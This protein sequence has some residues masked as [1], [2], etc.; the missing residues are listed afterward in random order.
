MEWLKR[1]LGFSSG[2]A[3]KVR[4]DDEQREEK[5]PE[6]EFIQVNLPQTSSES[7]NQNSNEI[8]DSAN[9]DPIGLASIPQLDSSTNQQGNR[10]RPS[11]EPQIQKPAALKNLKKVNNNTHI[12]HQPK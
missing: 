10:K 8:T 7:Q 3:K 4:F 11:K 9:E 12:I 6:E 5:P 2:N 1:K